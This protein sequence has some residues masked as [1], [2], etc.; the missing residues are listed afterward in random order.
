MQPN[1][2]A[3]VRR[4]ASRSRPDA[5]EAV[6]PVGSPKLGCCCAVNV[7]DPPETASGADEP[8][9]PAPRARHATLPRGP[10]LHRPTVAVLLLAL[11]AACQPA[12]TKPGESPPR[13]VPPGDL[14]RPC[15]RAA[16]AAAQLYGGAA[17]RDRQPAR[18]RSRQR[19]LSR[20]RAGL[21][22]RRRP[23][24][25]LPPPAAAAPPAARRASCQPPAG[26]AGCRPRLSCDSDLIDCR[27]PGQAAP[28]HAPPRAARHPIRS[29]RQTLAEAVGLTAPSTAP[30]PADGADP[31][32]DAPTALDRLGGLLGLDDDDAS[33]PAAAKDTA[34]TPL[35]LGSVVA[36]VPLARPGVRAG[37]GR[38]RSARSRAGPGPRCECGAPDRRAGRGDGRRT[39]SG[40]RRRPG[41]DPARRAT[42]P[43]YGR[44]RRQRRRG[45]GVSGA[46]S[47]FVSPRAACGF[48]WASKRARKPRP[49]SAPA[50]RDLCGPHP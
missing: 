37:R 12:A 50:R 20:R 27:R 10:C 22:H 11:L 2:R 3:L 30:A 4:P 39:R 38:R 18:G 8:V 44:R 49:R 47:R 16:A 25:R 36:R 33:A 9:A 31:G 14:S 7:V 17:R 15:Q 45:A 43:A 48:A 24:S 42:R 28:A 5:A 35:P 23:R 13:P 41:S 19:P 21:R 34:A 29:A 1:D 32:G 26:D 40:A 46:T 6:A